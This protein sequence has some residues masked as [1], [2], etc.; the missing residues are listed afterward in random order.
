MRDV[1]QQASAIVDEAKQQAATIL[2]RADAEA[3]RMRDD[4]RE[5]GFATGMER[6][7]EDGHAEGLA[8]GKAEALAH[9]NQQLTGLITALTTAL[10]EIETHRQALADEAAADVA[11]LAVAVAEKITRRQGVVDPAVLENNIAAA[12]R[13]ATDAHDVRLTLHP[14]Q[15]A[16]LTDTTDALQQKFPTLQH[17]KVIT[18]ES[19]APGGCRLTAVGCEVDTTLDTQL[20]RLAAELL[21]E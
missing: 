17:A 1:H 2:A 6:G 12:A 15:A 9:H 20:E 8:A 19:I 7:T 5:A 21:P 18:D 10:G 4:A 16:T 13:V 11:R 3:Q 14:D